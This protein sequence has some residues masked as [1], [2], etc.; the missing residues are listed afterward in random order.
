MKNIC[1]CF[2]V[3]FVLNSFAQTQ[4]IEVTVKKD[5]NEQLNET[6]AARKAEYREIQK[7]VGV[8]YLGNGEYKMT[9]VYDNGFARKKKIQIKVNE[10]LEI[11][12]NNKNADSYKVINT[13]LGRNG[14]D[15]WRADVV[16]NLIDDNGDVILNKDDTKADKKEAKQELLD[17]K[18]LLDMGIITQEEFNKKAEELKKILLAD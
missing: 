7:E 13:E 6:I 8:K 15:W 17:L 1:T 16:F 11:F 3:L 14:L 10:D 12:S 9:K 4:E 18:E 2:L 5:P